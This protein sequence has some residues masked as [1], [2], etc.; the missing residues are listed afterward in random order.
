MCSTAKIL[1][2]I[3]NSAIL[4]YIDIKRNMIN[5]HERKDKKFSDYK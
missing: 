2:Q 4:K 1:L 3:E 5:N